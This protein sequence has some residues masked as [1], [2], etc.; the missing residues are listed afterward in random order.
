MH[1]NRDP[2]AA[3]HKAES[4]VQELIYGFTFDVDRAKPDSHR[5]D[6][7]FDPGLTHLTV[8]VYKEY[9]PGVLYVSPCYAA[10]KQGS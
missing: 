5:S 9:L 3:L 4:G 7:G 2:P 8:D 1:D 6:R 10:C